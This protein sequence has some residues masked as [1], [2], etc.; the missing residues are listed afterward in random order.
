MGEEEKTGN[1]NAEN[2][3]GVNNQDE[4]QKV[5][6]GEGAGEANNHDN[7]SNEG[8]DAN[9]GDGTGES[10]KETNPNAN[11]NDADEEP[12]TRKRSNIDFILQRKNEKIEKLKNGKGGEQRPPEGDEDIDDEDAEIIDKRISKFMNPL[13]EKQAEDE[14]AKEIAEFVQKNPDFAKYANKVAKFSK[15]PTRKAVPISSI[16]YEVAG[17]DLIKLGADRARIADDK[18]RES[19]SGGSAGNGGAEKSVWDL[20]PEEFTAKQQEVMRKRRD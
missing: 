18:A 8:E 1:Q 12:K 20:T 19:G 11:P 4:S 9:N 15:H 13:L 5:N 3:E 7:K 16:F 10:Q 2:Q 14:D 17:E 6:N